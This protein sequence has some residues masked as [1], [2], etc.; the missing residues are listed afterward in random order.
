MTGATLFPISMLTSQA[1]NPIYRC[2]F[3][4]APASAGQGKG[5][6]PSPPLRRRPGSREPPPAAGGEGRA[7]TS[8]LSGPP[9]LAHARRRDSALLS[10]GAAPRR[11]AGLRGRGWDGKPE[12]N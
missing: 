5:S 6:A 12:W 4:F 1:T 10:A 3:P 9:G 2:P 11:A 7:L 8:L